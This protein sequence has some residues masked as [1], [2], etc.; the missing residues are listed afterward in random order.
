MSTA[1]LISLV[2]FALVWIGLLDFFFGFGWIFPPGLFESELESEAT[3]HAPQRQEQQAEGLTNQTPATVARPDRPEVITRE[4]AMAEMRET[5]ESELAAHGG[6]WD[7]WAQE[8]APFRA[9]VR[10]FLAKSGWAKAGKADM[11][12]IGT[13]LQGLLQDRY[14]HQAQGKRPVDAIIAL[15]EQ[16]RR[17][18]IDLIVM[19]IPDKAAVYPGRYSDN[20]PEDR[21]VALAMRRLMAELNEADVE[22]IDL[23]M[24]FDRWRRRDGDMHLLYQKYDTHWYNRGAQLAAEEIARR[25][26]RYDFVQDALAAGNPFVGEAVFAPPG[27]DML[28]DG[29]E[30]QREIAG[31]PGFRDKV[32]SVSYRDGRPYEDIADSPVIMTADS[33]GR[34]RIDESA[35]TS[36]Q[37]A[38]RIGMP[39]TM[40]HAMGSGPRIPVM[41][42]RELR[43][44]P[45]YL[46]GRKVFIW[47][48]VMRQFHKDDWPV[49]D[50]P[51]QD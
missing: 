2:I 41:L 11:R 31:D 4:Q 8:L 19:P 3:P 14:D 13:A 35:H 39:V 9:D 18:G 21:R 16:L 10:T 32:L 51:Q 7:A 45:D 30:F 23:F 22:A 34:I 33:F 20:V 47:T 1:R 5:I 17:R 26:K 12:F 6:S 49:V 43:R 42:Y 36:A 37:V 38:L 27:T 44:N 48:G 50:L 46:D 24:L 40:L 25:L 15:N 29:S 28:K